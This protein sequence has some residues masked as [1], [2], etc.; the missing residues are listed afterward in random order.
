M[1]AP[2]VG[3]IYDHA[4]QQNAFP[5]AVRNKQR[6]LLTFFRDPPQTDERYS[7]LFAPE[8]DQ[9]RA[10][11]QRVEDLWTATKDY[12]DADVQSAAPNDFLGRFWEMYLAA[13][14]LTK[15]QLIPSAQ[16]KLR[17][18]G[19]DMAVVSPAAFVEA[20]AARPGT[21]KDAVTEAEMFVVRDVPVAQITLRLRAAIEEKTRKHAGYVAKKILT[22]SDPYVIGINGSG[23]PS[24][25][26]EPDVPWIIKS[27]FPLGNRVIHLDRETL[28]TI[29]ESHEP[30]HDI[31]KASGASVS[32]DIFLGQSHAGISAIVYCW[33][34][35]YNM[36]SGPGCDFIVVHNPFATNPI[37][38]GV[39]PA[40]LECWLEGDHVRL[41]RRDG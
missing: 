25:R 20:I 9:E 13:G 14:L 16:R 33:V 26:G 28:K 36:P 12:L 4:P 31:I 24:T 34:D 30:E 18:G 6:E 19:P 39:L 27:V 21:G 5:L 41:E 11:R 3:R 17:A 40:G 35:E 1:L 15:L 38:H 29:G 7:R 32:K 10:A 22:P 37:A 8:F 2:L 23:V